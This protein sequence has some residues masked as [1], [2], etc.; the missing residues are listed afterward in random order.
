ML[1][2]ALPLGAALGSFAVALDSRW[3]PEAG[4]R[5]LLSRPSMCD[6][7]RARV[8]WY[9][10]I[11]IVSWLL[12][13]GRTRCCKARIGLREPF[14][15]LAGA[16]LMAALSSTLREPATYLAWSMISLAILTLAT[17]VASGLALALIDSRTRLLPNPLVLTVAV[18]GAIFASMDALLNNNVAGLLV[19]LSSSLAWWLAFWVLRLTSRGGMGIG[20]TKL[21]AAVGL[22]LGVFGIPVSLVGFFLAFA[23]GAIQGLL[24]MAI[25]RAGRKQQV[26]FGPAI[27]GGGAT[28]IIFGNQIWFGYLQ[29][30]TGFAI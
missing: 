16:V 23:F 15:E 10:N 2:V 27:L 9:D 8:A 22:W 11:P 13:G 6:S 19:P 18:S 3:S 28:A 26:P 25:K 17:A 14:G 21:A 29:L 5:D 12:L 30:V 1:W 4:W 7:C 24:V 20:D